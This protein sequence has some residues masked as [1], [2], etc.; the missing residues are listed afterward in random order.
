MWK[1][2]V[3]KEKYASVAG[4]KDEIAPPTVAHLFFWSGYPKIA[5][6]TLLLVFEIPICFPAVGPYHRRPPSPWR[7][8]VFW[9][10]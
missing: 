5:I 8:F 4:L 2:S 7:G 1:K 3:I 9:H 10:G 6:G